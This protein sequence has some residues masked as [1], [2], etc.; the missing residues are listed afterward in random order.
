MNSFSEGGQ[1]VPEPNH[2]CNHCSRWFQKNNLNIISN[3][4][5][6]VGSRAEAPPLCSFQGKGG[7][8]GPGLSRV[9]GFRG[10]L[11]SLHCGYHR[12]SHSTCTAQRFLPPGLLCKH[13]RWL[14]K[15]N[16][17]VWCLENFLEKFFQDMSI[18]IW[19]HKTL[20]SQLSLFTKDGLSRRMD[21]HLYSQE[22]LTIR[23]K[24]QR[25]ERNI[26]QQ[27]IWGCFGEQIIVGMPYLRLHCMTCT[28]SASQ[29]H[30]LSGDSCGVDVSLSIRTG[31][32]NPSLYLQHR[33]WH[34]V[35][36]RKR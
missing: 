27:D 33:W 30:L 12:G 7:G 22:P 4:L 14:C 31:R 13:N 20:G 26:L 36:T 8:R 29:I 2:G 5:A 17:E 35:G 10:V 32:D 24:L 15:H 6:R 21:L 28:C 9:P 25:T 19:K 11:K 3:S 16:S 18:T 1:N 23:T 34:I